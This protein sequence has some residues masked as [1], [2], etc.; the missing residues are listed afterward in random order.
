MSITSIRPAKKVPYLKKYLI[1]G[2]IFLFIFSIISFY[3]EKIP[4]ILGIA[5]KAKLTIQSS[6]N[7]AKVYSNN[8]YLGDTPVDSAEIKA[9]LNN[10]SIKGT[11]NTYTTTL[12]IVDKSENTVYRDLGVNKNLSSGINIWEGTLDDKKVELFVTPQN[13]KI[14][15]NEKEVTAEEISVLD[16][17]TYKFA[18]SSPGFKDS[19]FSVNV[20]E[21]FKT[22]IEVKLAPFPY[23]RDISKFSNY[24]NIYAVFSN[25]SDVFVSSKDWVDYFIYFTKKKGLTVKDLGNIKDP[26]FNYFVDSEGRIFDQLGSQVD[27][28]D[29][30]DNPESKNI[31]VLVKNSDKSFVNE[32]NYKSLLFFNSKM[33][34][35]SGSLIDDKKYSAKL[36]LLTNQTVPVSTLGV[37]TS[38]TETQSKEITKPSVS[39]STSPASSLNK[40]IV[41]IN[42]EWLRV[43][44]TPGGEELGKAY[45]NEE[46]DFISETSDGWIKINF[47]GVDGFV[48]K[49]YIKF[50]N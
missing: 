10:I 11:R 3:Q 15:V 25:N 19:S 14:T 21:G 34:L 18:I 41:V 50:K 39:I 16:K 31:A 45:Q 22:N 40:K 49:Q 13:S 38:S 35:D 46:Y 26:F 17:G 2:A 48:S 42:N 36:S 32:K 4:E 20:R 24:Q 23:T 43:R 1:F 12:N 28:L 30:I 27:T 7:G 9:G 37:S 8:K 5:K 33:V 6:E 47:K 29:S 44:K